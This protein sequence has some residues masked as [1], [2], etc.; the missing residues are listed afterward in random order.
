MKNY[1]VLQETCQHGDICDSQSSNSTYIPMCYD[2]VEK[3]DDLFS[4]AP[5][6]KPKN[7]LLF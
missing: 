1:C 6:D 2:K 5:R 7:F 3:S 4:E